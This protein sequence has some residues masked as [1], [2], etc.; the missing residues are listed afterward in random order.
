MLEEIE[1]LRS[2]L[3]KQASNMKDSKKKA[4][5]LQTE[6]ECLIYLNKNKKS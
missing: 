5:K 4:N 6:I 1:N 3:A 2:D